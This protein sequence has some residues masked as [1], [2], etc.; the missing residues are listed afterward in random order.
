MSH[1]LSNLQDIYFNMFQNSGTHY[2]NEPFQDFDEQTCKEILE[3][4]NK[5]AIEVL[6]ESYI[7]SDRNPPKYDNQNYTA[8]VPEDFKNA[9]QALMDA[10]WFRLDLPEELGGST[11]PP[12]LRWA[13]AELL[14]GA[15][16][17][18]FFYMAG[19]LFA[20]ILQEIGTEE[21]K[22]LAQH[23]VNNRWGATMVLTEPDAGSDVG[24]G[25]TT[26]TPQSDG[27]WHIEGVKRFITSGEHDLADNIIH[28]VLARPL[29][30]EGAGG[31]GTKGLSLFIVPKYHTDFLTGETSERNGVYA[32]NVED[33]MGLKASTTCELTFGQNGKPAVGYLVGNRHT[34]I[35]DMFR[36]IEW[37]RM[38][39]G[40]KS[41][42]QLSAAYLNALEYA[43]IRVQGSD[44]TQAA[45]KSAPKV[46]I[47]NHP[48]VKRM[49]MVM[50]SY[51]EGLRALV[52]Y[53]AQWQDTS[54]QLTKTEADETEQETAHKVVDFLLP[55]AKGFSS[56]KSAETLPTAMQ[57]L[58]GS[59]Y[60]KDYPIEQYIRDQHIDK[61]YEGVTHIQAQDFLFRKIFKDQFRT[62][63]VVTNDMSEKLSRVTSPELAKEKEEILKAQQDIETMLHT[64]GGWAISSMGD[65][66]K[67]IYKVG[68]TANRLLNSV[69]I[70]LLA[71]LLL[72]QANTANTLLK[73]GNLNGYSEEYLAGKVYTARFFISNILPEIAKDKHVVSRANES[74]LMELSEKNF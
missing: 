37:A 23:M 4:V 59:G 33:K 49:L 15:N 61:L 43:K 17:A 42:A 28:F 65:D 71:S 14:L 52:H 31:V 55:I 60:L 62:L 9:Y 35:Q 66:P 21:Q 63:G 20:A 6:A 32:T 51:S 16:P 22:Q 38:M 13:V 7:T 70:F 30:T 68:E 57:I 11:T 47:I 40:T 48:D 29:N 26:A 46:T 58:G 56:E 72:D 8:T 54:L 44:L 41:M 50:K 19:P 25:R 74:T 24:A 34:G 27:S 12:T 1:Y 10:E 67:A 36:I 73:N 3:E 45:D 69:G 2:G 39:V 53:T 64:I 5:L 18:M